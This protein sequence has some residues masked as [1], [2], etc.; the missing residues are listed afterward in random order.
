MKL[1]NHIDPDLFDVFIHEKVYLEFAEKFL[2]KYQNDA[3]KIDISK[4]TGFNAA[5]G[6]V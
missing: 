2:P 1:D 4:I 5:Y 3:D 6:K